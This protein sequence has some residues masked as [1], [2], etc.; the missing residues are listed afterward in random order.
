MFGRNTL[1]RLS[2]PAGKAPR[3][4]GPFCIFKKRKKG[5]KKK[6]FEFT[7]LCF[8]VTLRDLVDVGLLRDVYRLFEIEVLQNVI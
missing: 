6:R 8:S 5:K 1:G 7:P 4:A 2:N 3:R